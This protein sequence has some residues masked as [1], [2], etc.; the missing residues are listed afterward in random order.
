GYGVDRVIHLMQQQNLHI[1][2]FEETSGGFRV[3]LRNEPV[4]AAEQ[5][6]SSV[7]AVR[8]NGVFKGLEINPRQ[9]AALIYLHTPGNTRITNSDLQQLCPDVHPETIRRDLVDLVMKNILQKMG[10]KRGS[11]Y[12]LRRD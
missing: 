11:Y 7:S 9:E 10:Q 8:F 5:E 12:I 6:A 1:P 3:I 4:N 2:A